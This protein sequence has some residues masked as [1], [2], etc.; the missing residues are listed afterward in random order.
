MATVRPQVAQQFNTQVLAVQTT[1]TPLAGI[2]LTQAYID[3]IIICVFS[4]AANSVF[5]GDQG[6][7]TSTGIEIP[8]GV[9]VQ[10]PISNERP[11]YELQNPIL[12]MVA[13]VI[14]DNV[15]GFQVPFV[16]WDLTQL[17]LIAAVATNVVIAAPKRAWV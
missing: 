12:R 6:V 13:K 2:Q 10:F 5:F 17:Y 11:L 7:T 1:P 8:A 3:N 14:C 4:T 16:Y 9:S 15:E